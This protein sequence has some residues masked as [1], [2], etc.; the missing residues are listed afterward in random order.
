MFKVNYNVSLKK[1][2]SSTWS[3]FQ[4]EVSSAAAI[5]EALNCT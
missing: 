4:M 2:T 3:L 5:I 1:G